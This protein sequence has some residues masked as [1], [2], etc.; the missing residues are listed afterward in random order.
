MDS[1]SVDSTGTQAQYHTFWD[2]KVLSDKYANVLKSQGIK[3]G[4]RIFVM[5]PRIPEWYVVMLGSFKIGAIPMPATTL[6]TAKDIEYR[7]TDVT[8]V[9]NQ[10]KF[11]AL[12]FFWPGEKKLLN[13]APNTCLLYT[14]PS[15]R[16]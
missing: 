4:D 14:S 10:G 12:N 8:E 2:L 16:D 11:W 15:P 7:I 3:K 5:L 13:P 1:L 9:D 6:L